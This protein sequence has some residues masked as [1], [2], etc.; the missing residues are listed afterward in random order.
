MSN[1]RTSGSGAEAVQWQRRSQTSTRPSTLAG[2]SEGSV[3]SAR[4]WNRSRC[5]KHRVDRRSRRGQSS[6]SAPS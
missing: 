4:Q 5:L 1:H 3:D 6:A 2:S